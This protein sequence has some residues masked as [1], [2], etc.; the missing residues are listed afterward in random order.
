MSRRQRRAKRRAASTNEGNSARP[1]QVTRRRQRWF[2]AAAVV[3]S[4][5]L[6]WGVPEVLVRIAD[7][8]L[9]S[10][11]AIHFGG[12]PNSPT[13]FVKDPRLHWKLRPNVQLDFLSRPV[14]TDADGFRNSPQSDAEHL[15]LC[16]GDSTTFGWGMAQDEPF[17]AQLASLLPHDTWRVINAGVPGYS[18]FQIRLLA[19]QLVPRWKPDVVVI[20]VGNNEAWP[21]YESDR[22]L[23][24]KRGA[25]VAVTSLL[26]HSKFLVW[27][28]ERYQPKEPRTFTAPELQD[29][30]PRVSPAEFADNLERIL[31]I[32]REHRAR[33]IVLSPPV[34]LDVPPLRVDQFVAWSDWMQYVSR[35]N[36]L[37]KEH[38]YQ[39]A[40]D[41]VEKSLAADPGNFYYL[42]CKGSVLRAMG[43]QAEAREVFEQAFENHPYPERCKRSYREILRALAEK[44]HVAFVDVNALFLTAAAPDPPARLYLDWCH[45]TPEGHQL[46]AKALAPIVQE[47]IASGNEQ[48]EQ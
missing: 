24:E 33:T 42:W 18:S 17:A 38:R 23:D 15:V 11:R 45:P 36:G 4:L 39:E 34:N 21:V 6:F 16:L 46:I 25:I 22:E 32:A 14:R 7:P 9:H 47:K 40:L 30:E 48:V 1:P 20:C 13:L 35:L 41:G 5:G 19:E 26:S 44:H 3:L 8:P 43:Q 10:F 27:A 37:L 31:Q 2:R 28:A 12:D 29:A